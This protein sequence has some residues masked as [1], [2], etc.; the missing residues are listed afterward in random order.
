MSQQGGCYCG[1]VRYEIT[2]DPMYAFQCHCRECQRYSGGGPNYSMG[3]PEAAFSYVKGT[4]KIYSRTD[5]DAPAQREFCGDCGANLAS[6]SPNGPGVVF[7]KAGSLDD[8]SAYPGPQVAVY[9]CDKQ[10]FHQ[11]PEGL[12]TFDRLPG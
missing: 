4:P 11:I 12:P 10:S 8:M 1:A 9:C 5:L 2:A 3:V 7:V 6:R